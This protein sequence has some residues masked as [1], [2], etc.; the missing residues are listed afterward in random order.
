MDSFR[1][2]SIRGL[3]GCSHHQFC[4]HC[5]LG[6]A[7]QSN[8]CPVCFARFS[9]LASA[10]QRSSWLIP[11]DSIEVDHRDQHDDE[12]E[13]EE[14]EKAGGQDLC[15]NCGQ[16][17]LE[18]LCCAECWANYHVH[19]L[20]LVWRPDFDEWFC[21]DCIHNQP[22]K[23]QRRQN[24]QMRA[25]ESPKVKTRSAVRNCHLGPENCQ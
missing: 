6:W 2:D 25:A 7:E 17:V 3:L 15:T 21:G 1:Q 10:K 8:T 16:E 4:F 22:L 12:E 19:C 23:V 11:I 14:E 13:E 24:T 18:G 5:I 20:D 9:S